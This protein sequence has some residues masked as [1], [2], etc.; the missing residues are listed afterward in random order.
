MYDNK[1][2][3]KQGKVDIIIIAQ[4]RICIHPLFYSIKTHYESNHTF[5]KEEK[6][7]KFLSFWCECVYLRVGRFCP[8]RAPDLKTWLP[9]VVCHS[10]AVLKETPS[11]RIDIP[12]ML[13]CTHTPS[14]APPRTQMC[15]C[16]TSA[17][18]K[19]THARCVQAKRLKL[20]SFHTRYLT[21]NKPVYASYSSVTAAQSAGP[22]F[23]SPNKQVF[24]GTKNFARHATYH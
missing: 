12:H 18:K 8:C 13:Y 21:C 3:C 4:A 6:G 7:I 2:A 22:L 1:K 9:P 11:A 16:S 15:I 19:K 20:N 23:L 14:S 24:H 17:S 10:S 5:M